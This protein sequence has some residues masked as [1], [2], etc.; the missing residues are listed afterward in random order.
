MIIAH[1][2]GLTSCR[3]HAK[4]IMFINFSPSQHPY[5]AEAISTLI[6]KGHTRQQAEAD[7]ELQ[8][9]DSCPFALA[10]AHLPWAPSCWLFF[11]L[12]FFLHLGLL[13]SWLLGSLLSVCPFTNKLDPPAWTSQ[14]PVSVCLSAWLSMPPLSTLL[15]HPLLIPWG[16][17][18]GSCPQPCHVPPCSPC[19][20]WSPASSSGPG[21]GAPAAPP[22]SSHPAPCTVPPGSS[23]RPT[24]PLSPSPSSGAPCRC[25]PLWAQVHEG[26][27]QL[28][29]TGLG[30]GVGGGTPDLQLRAKG[31]WEPIVW[32]QRRG[33]RGW[34]FGSRGKGAR[35]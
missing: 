20:S 17:A 4:D 12:A 13:G 27:P 24:H 3:N 26:R 18:L 10:Q 2:T 19:C 11:C 28:W 35:G 33:N 23:C 8:P 14:G 7:F 6:S 5:K 30:S 9:P 31:D 25:P 21:L 16:R 29:S 34:R 32:S 22:G 1:A 15:L